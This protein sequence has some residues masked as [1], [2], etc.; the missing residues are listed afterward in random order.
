MCF[1]NDK[2]IG[3]S[4]LAILTILIIWYCT[5]FT[6]NICWHV[7]PLLDHE[8]LGIRESVCHFYVSPLPRLRAPST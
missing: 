8:L 6:V 4:M 2:A 7:S 3:I 1:L 5:N